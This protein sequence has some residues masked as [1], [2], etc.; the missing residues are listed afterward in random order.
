MDTNTLRTNVL[1]QAK[2]ATTTV[3]Q[4]TIQ[5]SADAQDKQKTIISGPTAGPTT[6]TPITANTTADLPTDTDS[7]TR[8]AP[9][10]HA[11]HLILQKD[12]E[13]HTQVS[14]G[15]SYHFHHTFK[16]RR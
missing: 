10:T 14:S 4:D 12:T 1:Q 13:P 16:T 7:S 2:N 6:E 11:D 9:V 15:Q 5:H 3:E 8:G